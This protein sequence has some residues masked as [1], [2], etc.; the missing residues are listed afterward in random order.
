MKTMPTKEGPTIFAPVA[1]KRFGA[2]V[3]K[4]LSTM[5]GALEETE[6]TGRELKLRPLEDVRGRSVYALH[7]LFGDALG[8]ANDR[9]CQM[10]FLIGT[11]KDAGA[12]HVTACV[13]YLAYARQD[14]RTE[15]RGPI[16][17]RYVAQMF[18][19]A[20]VDRVLAL[21]VHDPAAFDNAF[22]CEAVGLECASVFAAHFAAQAS[23]PPCTVVSPDIGGI[24][25]ARRFQ[26]ALQR[27]VGP[28]VEFG[29]LDKTRSGA[30]VGGTLFAGNVAGRSVI[31]LD[32][33]IDSG[34]TVLRA[35]DFCRRAG[36]VRV[37]VAATHASFAAGA[38]RLFEPGHADSVVVTD[39]V[40]MGESFAGYSSGP[41]IVLEAAPVFADAIRRLEMT[42]DGSLRV[43]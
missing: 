31:I 11:L 21:E 14:R 23:A 42:A 17:T 18:E 10:L 12:S 29:I 41:L 3:A 2:A 24:K 35:I 43:T 25:R 22:R 38:H 15:A 36:A 33:L 1:S 28:S 16:T 6:F 27:L 20:G 8:S 5:L 30:V 37:D 34:S 32:D 7:S 13:P 39:S 26:E 4:C 19:A 40:V 9:L